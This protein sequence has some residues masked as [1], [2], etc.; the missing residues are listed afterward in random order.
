MDNPLALGS[1]TACMELRQAK[2]Q[3]KSAPAASSVA[4]RKSWPVGHGST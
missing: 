2:H 4:A 3:T 1:H